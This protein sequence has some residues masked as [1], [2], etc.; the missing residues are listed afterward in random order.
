MTRARHIAK[1]R[2]TEMA[3]ISNQAA[4]ALKAATCS[5]GKYKGLLLSRPPK[6]TSDAYAAWQAAQAVCNPHKVSI[7]GLIMMAGPQLVLYE[8]I[9]AALESVGVRNMDRDRNALDRLGVW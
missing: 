1:Q 5:R 6:S 8:E 9:K 3:V 7:F 4:I 2:K